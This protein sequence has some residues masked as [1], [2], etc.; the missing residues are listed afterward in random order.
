MFLSR[1]TKK[2]KI[3]FIKLAHFVSRIDGHVATQ[4]ELTIFSYCREMKISDVNFILDEYDLEKSLLA[5]ENRQT[6]KIFILEVMALIYSD[7]IY[8][9][10]EDEVLKRMLEIF[11]LD[12]NLLVIYNQWAK[13]AISLQ[14]Q[15][16]A[17]INL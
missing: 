6:K 10:K 17:L 5:I 13:N 7:E 9:I 1:L 8:H 14:L 15:G 3:E 12:P 2:E 4:E 16:E 11:K